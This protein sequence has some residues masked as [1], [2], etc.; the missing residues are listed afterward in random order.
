MHPI[1]IL[2]KVLPTPVYNL[3]RRY[4][5]AYLAKKY[6]KFGRS[7]VKAE[8][9]KAKPRRQKEGFYEKFINGKGLDIGYGGDPIAPDVQGWDFEHGDAQ[10][11]ATL[12]DDTFDYVYSSHTLEHMVNA[13]TALE[14]WFR[15]VKPGGYLIIYFPHRDLYEKKLTLPSR[16]NPDHKAFFLLDRD[17]KPDTIGLIPLIERSLKNYEIIYAKVCD[18]GYVNPGETEHSLGE[19]SLE[20]V[21]QKKKS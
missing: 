13:G 21:I 4:Y 17:E 14:N 9:T 7:Y 11:L 16:F 6:L 2:N 3:L 10:Y 1:T 15:V 18:D 19:Y 5:R 20:A 12:K 8:T